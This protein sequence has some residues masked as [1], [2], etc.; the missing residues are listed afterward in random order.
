MSNLDGCTYHFP[1]GA[2]GRQ[3]P[4]TLAVEGLEFLLALLVAE[5]LLYVNCVQLIFPIRFIHSPDVVLS[6]HIVLGNS[7]P[8]E[9]AH[10]GAPALPPANEPKARGWRRSWR[11]WWR[12]WWRW[13]RRWWWRC[14]WT[15][16]L[17]LLTRTSQD[18]WDAVMI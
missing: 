13:W 9:I 15:P 3:A 8:I 1:P 17:H 11:W 7:L 10:P 14:G 16:W 2:I 6:D 5:Q 12:R 18:V 4:E